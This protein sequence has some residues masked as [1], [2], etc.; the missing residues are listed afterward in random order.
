MVLSLSG[1]QPATAPCSDAG[2]AY[3]WVHSVRI[4]TKN[5]LCVDPFWP[6]FSF[7]KIFT[8]KCRVTGRLNLKHK[9]H[10]GEKPNRFSLRLLSDKLLEPSSDP[11]AGE[12][13]QNPFA[14][15]YIL[16]RRPALFT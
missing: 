4:R 9:F 10:A 7:P 13:A 1:V 14:K 8:V 15:A 16:P 3:S 11:A 12:S 6:I 2:V 5:G